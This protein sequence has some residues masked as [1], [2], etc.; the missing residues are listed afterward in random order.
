MP[1]QWHALE[2]WMKKFAFKL[3]ATL[4]LLVMAAGAG[5]LYATLAPGNRQHLGNSSCAGCHLAGD[6]VNAENASILTA[7][8][9]IL[10]GQ[11]HPKAIQVS[12][13][14]GFAPKNKP[15]S[16]YPL[17]WKGDLTCSTCHEIHGSG[18]GLM[19]GTQRGK[20]LCLSCHNDQFFAKMRD[21]GAS[22]QVGHL[23]GGS[24]VAAFLD[25]YSA[26]CMSCHDQSGNPKFA[27]AVDQNGVVRHAGRSVNHPIGV[28]YNKSAIYGGYRPM[29]MISKKILLPDGKLSC[30]SCHQGYAREH[31]KLVMGNTGSALCFECHDL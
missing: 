31:G 23:G 10:C 12:H 6:R 18:N 26:K 4:T 28:N 15:P 2:A 27:T 21:R 16:T 5:V 29:H 17:D 13:P 25:A 24:F 30:V 3:A 14:S 7:S 9:E 22:T 20:A 19:R 11:C 1:T 8:Q